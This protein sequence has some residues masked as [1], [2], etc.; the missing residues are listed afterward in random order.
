MAIAE[1]LRSADRLRSPLQGGQ[2]AERVAADSGAPAR[3]RS[4]RCGSLPAL[5]DVRPAQRLWR[6]PPSA[7]A[8]GPGGRRFASTA[9]SYVS[10]VARAPEFRSR[11]DRPTTLCRRAEGYRHNAANR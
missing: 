2:A 7:R 6:T 4:H 1:H 5:P 10:R 8:T 11:P 3:P 9:A